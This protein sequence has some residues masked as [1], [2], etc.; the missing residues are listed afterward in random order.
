MKN[1]EINTNGLKPSQS[2][3][4]N[5]TKS[6]EPKYIY[7][8][9]AS[10]SLQSLNPK[11]KKEPV[12]NSSVLNSLS[13]ESQRVIQEI[14]QKNSALSSS[15][16]GNILAFEFYNRIQAIEIKEINNLEQAKNV[17]C[18][19]FFRDLILLQSRAI[20]KFSEPN[21]LLERFF[22]SDH[23]SKENFRK[24]SSELEKFDFSKMEENKK[25]QR[26][27]KK[28]I[29]NQLKPTKDLIK[30][31]Q[32]ILLCPD[33]VKDQ[34]ILSSGAEFCKE[35]KIKK[36]DLLQ[37]LRKY[38]RFLKLSLEN[39]NTGRI[40]GLKMNMKVLDELL[41]RKD[42][43]DQKKDELSFFI[44]EYFEVLKGLAKLYNEDLSCLTPARE[45]TLTHEEYLKKT[46]TKKMVSIPQNEMPQFILTRIIGTQ[47]VFNFQASLLILFEKTF[48]ENKKEYISSS[49]SAKLFFD[50]LHTY[51][52]SS[53]ENIEMTHEISRLFLEDC[54]H[55]KNAIHHYMP[56]DIKDKVLNFKE[57]AILEI[58]ISMKKSINNLSNIEM[59][60]FDLVR[61][62]EEKFIRE[63]PNPSDMET[64]RKEF[65]A[66]AA[67]FNPLL[68]ALA[69][70]NNLLNL[71]YLDNSSHRFSE[72]VLE[73]FEM[74]ENIKPKEEPVET[75]QEDPCIVETKNEVPVKQ[76][77]DEPVEIPKIEKP[78][79]QNKILTEEV[80]LSDKN[81]SEKELEE[82][83]IPRGMK[84]RKVL[85]MLRKL[86]YVQE[87]K[88][89]S[90]ALLVNEQG[91]HVLFSAHKAGDSFKQGTSRA[92][93]KSV[94]KSL[95]KK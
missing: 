52:S 88:R 12:E 73:L 42:F 54:N 81:E 19:E 80:I 92:M 56:P 51:F 55:L 71:G 26:L 39:E 60:I 15:S 85:Q 34:I 10:S 13:S 1:I 78:L 5:Q 90:H 61:K 53:T 41:Q 29:E 66:V 3:N 25:I 28:V 45:G 62:Y 47:L 70:G 27:K 86:G 46:G 14:C 44:S 63:P 40:L 57:G 67:S 35:E 69:A 7:D 89:G 75:S 93:E 74:I 17:I 23:I 6:K 95:A 77:V 2:L 30:L 50:S 49:D 33:K 64:V 94:N 24:A 76:A 83:K 91:G 68:E 58:L 43:S 59:T 22:G 11:E 79:E 31:I 4:Q 20:A 48:L 32:E 65:L 16:L 72:R 87:R 9:L 37:F 84:S 8:T 18:N 21:P 36:S 38:S 82:F